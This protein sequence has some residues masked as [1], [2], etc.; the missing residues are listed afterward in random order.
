MDYIGDNNGRIEI[1]FMEDFIQK[2]KEEWAKN[3]NKTD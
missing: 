1:N 3:D 2:E